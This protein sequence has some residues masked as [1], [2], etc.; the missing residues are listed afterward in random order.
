MI[1]IILFIVLI[2]LSIFTSII[3]VRSENKKDKNLLEHKIYNDFVELSK[4]S[5][6]E[7]YKEYLNSDHWKAIRLKA[8]DR[9]GY[10]CQLCSSKQHLN[11]HH[12]TY[13][14]KGYELFETMANNISLEVT[15]Y[16]LNMKV[17]KV[18]ESKV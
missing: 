17:V 16:T 8:L 11:V 14:N 3:I 15:M 5:P 7:E 9:A 10:R 1:Y 18:Q 2:L 12:N 4:K 6:K 13:I